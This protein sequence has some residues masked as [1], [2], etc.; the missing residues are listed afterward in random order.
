MLLRAGEHRTGNWIVR[1]LEGVA[2]WTLLYIDLE[3]IAAIRKAA[4]DAFQAMAK[5]FQR[6]VDAATVQ[7]PLQ[8]I[9]ESW[10]G[11]YRDARIA[12]GYV[13]SRA[14]QQKKLD[15]LAVIVTVTVTVTGLMMST[16]VATIGVRLSPRRCRRLRRLSRARMMSTRALGLRGRVRRHSRDRHSANRQEHASTDDLS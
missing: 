16:V 9:V 10:R 15:A 3:H 14:R 2:Q 11:S 5:R 8:L 12:A 7:I 1:D 6:N 13:S 4:D